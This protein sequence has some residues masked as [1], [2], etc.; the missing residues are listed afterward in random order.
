MGT[1]TGT[2]VTSSSI[3]VRLKRSL[4][5]R[6]AGVATKPCRRPRSATSGTRSVKLAHG[7]SARQ[8]RR[9]GKVRARG[10]PAR[11][12]S[13]APLRG[14]TY[15]ANERCSHMHWRVWPCAASGVW[16]FLR[17][18]GAPRRNRPF[19]SFPQE[20]HPPSCPTPRLCLRGGGQPNTPILATRY[21]RPSGAPR[22][23][24]RRRSRPR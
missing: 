7:T 10:R 9:G 24:R 11:T 8:G 21:C 15:G 23:G 6:S 2:G 4:A 12:K 16:S 20:A 18:R 13:R 17:P 19:R 14:C 22:A 5:S 3:F 1:G